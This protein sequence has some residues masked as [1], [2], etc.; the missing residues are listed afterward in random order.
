MLQVRESL[1]QTHLEASGTAAENA[2]PYPRPPDPMFDFREI[3]ERVENWKAN[4]LSA[5]L[6]QADT[7]DAELNQLILIGNVKQPSQLDFPA[8][9]PRRSDV[10]KALKRKNSRSRKGQ[11]TSRYFRTAAAPK[12]PDAAN[13]DTEGVTRT[14]SQPRGSNVDPTPCAQREAFEENLVA[15]RPS[16]PLAIAAGRESIQQVSE[17]WPIT[18]PF[19]VTHNCSAVSSALVPVI[20]SHIHTAPAI[21]SKQSSFST[22]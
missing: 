8:V 9:K 18:L 12:L 17:V 13:H 21:Y 11:A 6:S 1:A 7:Q 19:C 3:R 14:I 2:D 16:S 22:H 4:V 5:P 10:A 15:E 20:P